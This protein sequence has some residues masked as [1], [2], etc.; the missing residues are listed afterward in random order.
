M[1]DRSNFRINQHAPTYARCQECEGRGYVHQLENGEP[2]E[3]HR[4]DRVTCPDCWGTNRCPIPITEVIGHL[5][6]GNESELTPLKTE[7]WW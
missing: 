7:D 4:E 6:M 1:S 5:R 2:G 3:A